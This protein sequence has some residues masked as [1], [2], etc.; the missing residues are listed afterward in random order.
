MLASYRSEKTR[1]CKQLG[2]TIVKT[3]RPF[4]TAHLPVKVNLTNLYYI[5]QADQRPDACFH[6]ESPDL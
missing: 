6:A 1:I 4:A 5:L 3:W 2:E